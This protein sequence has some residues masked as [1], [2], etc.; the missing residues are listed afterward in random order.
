MPMITDK[1]RAIPRRE[2]LSF[3]GASFDVVINVESSHCNENLPAF[4]R[5]VRRVLRPEGCFGWVDIRGRQHYRG[6]G[7]CVC[8]VRHAE[9]NGPLVV[10]SMENTHDRKLAL[11]NRLWMGKAIARVCC[12]E[13]FVDLSFLEKWRDAVSMQ[14]PGEIGFVNKE[15]L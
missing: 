7:A 1:N 4:L 5:E 9:V 10:R 12:Y 13:R 14:N 3:E 6:N 2:A 11:I 15:S 8:R